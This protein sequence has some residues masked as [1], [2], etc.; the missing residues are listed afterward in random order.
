MN[1]MILS[2]AA[3]L[4]SA[5]SRPH[6][7]AIVTYRIAAPPNSVIRY[8]GEDYHTGRSGSI[9]LI[10]DPAVNTVAVA[11]SVFN[12]PQN[13]PTDGFGSVTVSLMPQSE[14]YKSGLQPRGAKTRAAR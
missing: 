11:E 4:A 8:A 6:S 14:G 9:E 12:L 2:L 3:I 1:M 5:T 7:V 10:A 13:G